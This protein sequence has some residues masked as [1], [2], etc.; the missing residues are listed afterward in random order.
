MSNNEWTGTAWRYADPADVAS[1]IAPG[2]ALG[3]A[4][5]GFRG[6]VMEYAVREIAPQVWRVDIAGVV[7]IVRYRPDSV[8]FSPWDVST[9]EGRR[10]W[11][12][13]SLGSAFRWIEARTGHPV[14]ALLVDSLLEQAA[15]HPASPPLKVPDNL[16]GHEEPRTDDAVAGRRG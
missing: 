5:S 10:V 13:T 12:A 16:P 9:A 8:T 15:A 3:D 4:A 6:S 7:R 2:S 14:Q 1:W 11:S